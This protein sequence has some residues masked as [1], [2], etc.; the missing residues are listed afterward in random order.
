MTTIL[1]FGVASLFAFWVWDLKNQIET[2]QQCVSATPLRAPQ[3]PPPAP[4][5][6]RECR[7]I[8]QAAARAAAHRTRE[9][10]VSVW[11]IE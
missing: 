5:P 7:P 3:A 6:A 11:T 9:D 4:T 10:N 8:G 1:S 2:L